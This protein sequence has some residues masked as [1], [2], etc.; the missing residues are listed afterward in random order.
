MGDAPMPPGG[1][2]TT[3]SASTTSAATPGAIDLNYPAGE[4]GV[5]RSTRSRPHL[6]KLGFRTIWQVED[7]FDHMHVDVR[8]A[9][10]RSASAA[11]SARLGLAEPTVP[12]GQARRLGRAGAGRP[13]GLFVGGAGGIPFGPPDPK[14]A[15]ADLRGARPLQR[16]PEGAPGGIGDGDRRVGRAE[17]ADQTTATSL[18]PF[19][20]IRARAG[21]RR[22]SG[23]TR[24]TRPRSS[25]ATRRRSRTATPTPARSRRRCSAPRIPLRY[26]QRAGQAAALNDKFCGGK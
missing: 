25:S 10:R 14:I 21:G 1:E 6:I 4:R 16:L 11:G 19:Q 7:H 13:R 8:A 17:P 24:T 12:A 9:R 2:R 3:T 23:W 15:I 22:R 20:Q 26:D 18:G 5:G